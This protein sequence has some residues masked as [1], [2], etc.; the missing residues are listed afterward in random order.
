MA[1][2]DNE[3]VQDQIVKSEQDRT[4]ASR[5]QSAM[6]YDLLS[7]GEIY[8]LDNGMASIF[9]NG[10]RLIDEDNWNI[11]K[12]KRTAA[13]ITCSAGSTTITVPN[14]M[15]NVH[16][17]TTDGQRYIRIQKGLATLAGNGSS[18]GATGVVNTETI[19]T[20]ANFFTSSMVAST[21]EKNG[22]VPR[23]R[24]AGL[25][26]NGTEY[27]G[28]VTRVVS[29]QEAE[30]TPAISTGGTHKTIFCDYVGKVTAYGGSTSITVET[31]PALAVSGGA[32]QMSTPFIESETFNDY[33][34]YKNVHVNFRT[35]GRHQRPSPRYGETQT[36]SAS[37]AI[38]PNEEIKQNN[39]WSSL[40]N[41]PSNYNDTEL[42][43][44]YDPSEGQAN[45]TVLT[46]TGAGSKAF[47][48]AA[49]GDT[50][51]VKVVL[52]FPQGLNAQ[53][54]KTESAGEKAAAHA[55]FQ[56][57][58]EYTR[59]G[60]N[61]NSV[62]LVG[63]TDND[64]NTRGTSDAVLLANTGMEKAHHAWGPVNF[65]TA[66][67]KT[68][69]TGY[70]VT[71]SKSAMFEEF[72][73]PI[74]KYKP[75]SN[76]RVRLRKVTADNPLSQGGD[77]QFTNASI[78]FAAEAQVHDWLSYPNSAYA[79]V[80][81][82]ASDFSSS[83]L[84]ARQYEIKGIKCQ[85]PTNYNAR[86][87][88]NDTANASYTRDISDGTNEA[89][90][91]NWDGNMRGD[92]STYN[93]SS[94]NY[95]KVWT[96]NPA[97][98]FYD[99]MTNK[100]YGLGQYI[101]P[102]QINKYE[103]YQIARYCD[104]LVS[105]GKGG[106]EPRFSANV[107]LSNSQ[108]A[109]KV[110]KDFAS[111]FRGIL[112]WH[113][114]KITAATDREKDP[115]YTF[116]KGNVINGAFTYEGT[117]KKLRTNQVRVTWNNPDLMYRQEVSIVDDTTN[118]VDQ[119]RIVSK[120]VLAYGCTSEGQ[121][122]RYG[123]WHMLS[124]KLQKEIVKFSTGM[125]AAFLKPGDVIQ[126]QDADRSRVQFSGRISNT[127]TRSTTVIPLDRSITL[128][129][130]TTYELTV[131]SPQEACYLTDTTETSY[132]GQTFGGHANAL[133]N[134][135]GGG[136]YTN[137]TYTNIPTTGGTG[138]DLR[139]DVTVSSN[140]VSNVSINNKG[141]GYTDN[142]DITVTNYGSFTTSGTKATFKVNGLGS[143]TTGVK[144]GDLMTFVKTEEGAS[145]LRNTSNVPVDVMF[146]PDSRIEKQ[147]VSTSAGS[148]SSL[149]V[150]TAFS[151][152]PDASS[153]WALMGSSTTTG[154]VAEGVTGSYKKYQ[155][156]SISEDNKQTYAI[157]ALEYADDKF[158]EVDRGWTVTSPTYNR[159]KYGDSVP[160]PTS[161]AVE[162]SPVTPGSTSPSATVYI[163][164]SIT[165]N[166]ATISWAAP[167]TTRTDA[168]GNTINTEYEYIDSYEIEHTFTKD[169]TRGTTYEVITVDSGT[170]V[171]IPSINLGTYRVR[172]RT[173]NTLGNYSPWVAVE[174]GT[175]TNLPSHP[176]ARTYMLPTG[177]DLSTTLSISS[178]T[179]SLGAGAT[180]TYKFANT[181]GNTLVV[182]S[183]SAAKGT[184]N[185][186]GMGASSTAYL[187]IDHSV[188]DLKAIEL[189][190][191]TTTT[192]GTSSTKQRYTYWKEVGASNN[193]LTAA[194]G[195]VSMALGSTTVTGSSTDFDGEF[196]VG[197]FIKIGSGTSYN[198][199]SDY[200]RITKITSDTEM[201]VD[202]A[203]GRAYSGATA[204][205]QTWRPDYNFDTV[206]AKVTT[207]SSTN[208]TLETLCSYSATQIEKDDL[209]SGIQT[210][211]V[212]LTANKYAIAY[213][214]DGG[215]SDSITFTAEPQ[216][217]QGTATYKF[218]LD[219]TTEQ[220]ASTTATYALPDSD[221]PASGAAKL[222]K[223][224][225]YD[226]G[227]AK[228]TDSVSIYG[229]QDG[230]DAITVILTNEAHAL[231][232]TSGGTVTYTNSGTDIRVFKGSAALAY[233]T[234]NSQFTVSASASNITAGSASTVSTYTRRYAAAS[235]I[236]AATATI[237][238]TVAVKNALGTSTSFTKVQTLNKTTDGDTG[239]TGAAGT[240][241]YTWTKYGTNSS[242]AGLTDTYTAGTTT[243]IGMAFQQ[244]SATE[245]T[246]A[247]DYT[248]HKIEGEDGVQ[249]DT[250]ATGATTYTWVKY[251]T[252]SSGAGLTNTYTAGTTLYIGMAFNKTT[253]T[254]ST[255]AGDYTWTK[256]EGEDGSDGAAGAAGAAGLNTATVALYRKNTSSS[257]APAAFSGTFT[258]TFSTG[259]VTGGTLNSWTATPPTATNGE[260]IWVRQAT[261][262]STGTT[263]S[264]PTSEFSAAVVH[265]GVGAAG[266]TGPQ[267]A[268][269]EP[270]N[271]G[272]DGPAGPTGAAGL[273]NAIVS[274]YR[275]STS[276]SSAP[277]AFTGTMTYTFSTNA[278]SGGTLNSWTQSIPTVPANNYLWV[279]QAT[280]SSNTTTDSI[281]INEWS[282]AIVLSAAIT[283][284]QGSQGA[285]GDTGATGATGAAGA[286]GITVS[287]TMPFMFWA[288][289][290]N[291]TTYTPNQNQES[292]VTF[293]Q[294]STTLGTAVIRGSINTSTGVITMST[295]SSSGVDSINHG[296]ASSFVQTT[297]TEGTATA[298]VS[299]QATNMGNLG[300]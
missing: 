73:L 108:S 128:A 207:D 130:N 157:S 226:D 242:G 243:Y 29:A 49:P 54:I 209:A 162:V 23:I 186:S 60:S 39:R 90:Y 125:N 148:V 205:Y 56:I 183:A 27:V 71:Y 188:P 268:Q 248:W 173:K 69:N 189:A 199:T 239:A 74:D 283:G 172:V 13:G 63:P 229:I 227:V 123:K 133:D 204:A 75:F 102:S 140:A 194:S 137:G 164:D 118:I 233:G 240:T 219:G 254:E 280:A 57:F 214:I 257:S 120:Q 267:G 145:N 163:A 245:S 111:I 67:F 275:I 50:D 66:K 159:L 190:V 177:G 203:A 225:M 269:G 255:N 144:N 34:N 192:S 105:D 223:V 288:S 51:T 30:V 290:D 215:E 92:V 16:H 171:E 6:I 244:T 217:I 297:L 84:P 147:T 99:L 97:W 277:T 32:G 86:Y 24:V 202:A 296:T 198:A 165:D 196:E 270:G 261:A 211:S 151:A 256:I 5:Y 80:A 2:T 98:I 187:A 107:Y 48:L 106:T 21:N 45:D 116:T 40:S 85:V 293:K 94:V 134:L 114:G 89:T 152:T 299:G 295:V 131:I 11:Y 4:S 175:G 272:D 82:N 31:A 101:D 83:S 250:G 236:S 64:I 103:L 230:E 68:P 17:A 241:Y 26:P 258:Y 112:F 96:D 281:A 37:F 119:G 115:I 1:K 127:G 10:T 12:P 298:T 132:S 252:N 169:Q 142:D 191:D 170:S 182:S 47:G 25:G 58:F 224:T 62:Q 195:T 121:A 292:T 14:D 231:A 3:I 9:I 150:D 289:G 109:F 42:T 158:T 235:S 8:G 88:L 286:A 201:T 122:L 260:Y 36:P 20:T 155:I 218:D 7:E 126:V 87:E 22:L 35:G 249:G 167:L 263:D 138:F 46:A 300:K 91:Q 176:G 18:T 100:R 154:D 262:S 55:E 212:R 282:S 146:S 166:K 78:L 160:K 41:I 38:S 149:T 76:W 79:A 77:W 135:S 117:S 232:T 110:M 273:N 208:Y 266:G 156:A 221:E 141:Y 95:N 278:L 124:E 265:S 274:L 53:K 237:T 72:L 161:V 228:A 104:E 93:R 251:G 210:W 213:N 294:G 247:G 200:F 216:G 136:G 44:D 185:F 168:E 291:G 264:V 139:V 81:L 174:G 179:V 52:K 43:S 181:V 220:A 143:N 234:G 287:N 153:I 129:A 238:F 259:A 61:Y 271:Q 59:D 180:Q 253:A 19:T 28:E 285:Q 279:R 197:D 246:T 70:I 113:D 184:Q 33:L 65:N 193:G 284:A 206:I 15:G 222:V 178:S 276:N